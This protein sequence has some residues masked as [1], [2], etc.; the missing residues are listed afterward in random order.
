MPSPNMPSPNM[1]SPDMQA[2]DMPSPDMQTPPISKPSMGMQS[3]GMAT[4]LMSKPQMGMQAPGMPM[5]SGGDSNSNSSPSLNNL[6]S[7]LEDLDS[8][9]PTNSKH[10]SSTSSSN[11][12]KANQLSAMDSSSTS[13]STKSSNNSKEPMQSN[14][15]NNLAMNNLSKTS[16]L[17]N[18]LLTQFIDFVKTHSKIAKFDPKNLDNYGMTELATSAFKGSLNYDPT[19]PNTGK[20]SISEEKMDNF[21]VKNTIDKVIK[22]NLDDAK[23]ADLINIYSDMKTKYIN[24]CEA[25]LSILENHILTKVGSE[26]NM[27]FTIKDIGY[28]DLVEQETNVRNNIGNMYAECHLNYQSG[29]SALYSA[30][31]S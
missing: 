31:T 28:A 9:K 8:E 2:P 5:Q 22:I 10:S 19:D 30:L 3:P 1:P 14:S 17:K 23:F 18:D 20:L 21:C 12:V 15:G 24:N 26:S 29:I 11:V 4:P 7:N 25:L 16:L 6:N 13:T 27:R